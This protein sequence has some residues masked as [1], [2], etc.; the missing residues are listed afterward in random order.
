M[1]MKRKMMM[2]KKMRIKMTKT[3]KSKLHTTILTGKTV[4]NNISY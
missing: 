1:R 4:Y 3:R 2:R